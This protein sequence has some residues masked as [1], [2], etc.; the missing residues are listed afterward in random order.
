MHHQ[1]TVI[2]GV[3]APA[4][5]HQA[6][7]SAARTASGDLDRIEQAA[8]S[9][10]D[11]MRGPEAFGPEVD[12]PANADRHALPAAVPMSATR[13]SVGAMRAARVHHFGDSLQIDELPDPRPSSGE[14]VVDVEYVGVN[15]LD[16]WV[17]QGTVAGG[18]QPLPF[19]PGVEA[20][21]TVGGQQFAIQAP[22]YGTVQDGL[23]LQHASVPET[24][25][26]PVPEGVDPVQAAVLPVTGATA[27]RLVNEVAPVAATDR[28]IV[29]GASGGVGSLVIQLAKAKGAVVWGQTRS[30]EKAEWITALGA[31]RAVV[32]TAEDLGT[33]LTE[34]APTIAF[35]S[36]GGRF[37]KSLVEVLELGGRIGLVG[38]SSNPE[39]MLDLR[40][41]YR[42]GVSMLPGSMPPHRA[43]PALEAVLAD[44]AAGHL[45]VMVDQVLP[46]EG[47]A[48][49]HRRILDGRVRGKLLL[50]P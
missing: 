28:V 24:A 23:Y 46:L 5:S 50:R 6:S 11:T 29:L 40:T 27:W 33:E 41:M 45:Q 19:I 26:V 18:N 44:L 30:H 37:T 4:R 43:R 9:F 32:A 47:A 39:A 8:K 48:D 7:R 21:G 17:T 35:D 2:V 22:G 15:P 13:P 49:A 20:V 34:F 38:T 14:V 10:G 3:H 42:K 25:L 1:R 31:D 12:A 16:V 36:L